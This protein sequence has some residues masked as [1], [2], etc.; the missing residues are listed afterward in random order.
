MLLEDFKKGS[1]V[2]LWTFKN[3][4]SGWYVENGL[5][6]HREKRKQRD[7]CG[8]CCARGNGILDRVVAWE[9][10]RSGWVQKTHKEELMVLDEELDLEFKESQKIPSFM[11]QQVSELLILFMGGQ[12]GSKCSL[13]VPVKFYIPVL[14]IPYRGKIFSIVYNF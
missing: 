12:S 6:G 7:K 5:K 2:V 10:M 1:E 4:H 9:V 11:P 14:F 3:D 13:S 8:Y